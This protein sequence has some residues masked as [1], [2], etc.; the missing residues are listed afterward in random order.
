[1]EG[2]GRNW[3]T[4]KRRVQWRDQ[5]SSGTG[6]ALGEERIDEEMGSSEGRV[7]SRMLF[8]GDGGGRKGPAS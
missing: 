4:R 2:A 8:W 3:E 5:T 6:Q 7:I 1:M